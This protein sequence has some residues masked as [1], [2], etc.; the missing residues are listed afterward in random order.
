[1]RRRV[2]LQAGQDS[3]HGLGC[4]SLLGRSSHLRS[5]T[6]RES[7]VRS[8]GLAPAQRQQAILL[9]VTLG[10]F[11]L[12]HT[13]FLQSG[14]K[15]FPGEAPYNNP[16]PQPNRDTQPAVSRSTVSPLKPTNGPYHLPQGGQMPLPPASCS[17]C[18]CLIAALPGLCYN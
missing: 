16:Y 13:Q 2:W 6:L 15:R 9:S 3:G 17:S 5:F 7:K 14:Q 12:R 1:M 4:M 18:S 8:V 10:L 11:C